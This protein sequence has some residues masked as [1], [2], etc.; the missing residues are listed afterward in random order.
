MRPSA[1]AKR[2]RRLVLP[3]QREDEFC[4]RKERKRRLVLPAQRKFQLCRRKEGKRR[5]V[6]PT[7]RGEERTSFSKAFGRQAPSVSQ[8]RCKEK[9]LPAQKGKD[10][11]SF[12]D[13]FRNPEKE[14]LKGCKTK[15]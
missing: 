8:C 13:E 1:D 9:N 15:G 5:L 11:I 14:R 7:Q 12:A 10:K 6:L 4:R 2:E 3:T